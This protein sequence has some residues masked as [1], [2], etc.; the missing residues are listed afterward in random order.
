LNKF[1]SHTESSS[2][3]NKWSETVKLLRDE[4]KGYKIGFANLVSGPPNPDATRK[5][6]EVFTSA[7]FKEVPMAETVKVMSNGI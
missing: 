4:F 1:R 5:I 2:F 7:G 3:Y 6:G